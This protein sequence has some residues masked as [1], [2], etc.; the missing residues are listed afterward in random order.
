M[1]G[2]RLRGILKSVLAGFLG[3]YTSRYSEFEGYWLFGFLLDAPPQLKVDL[4]EDCSKPAGEPAMRVAVELA[5]TKFAEQLE[6][7]HVPRAQVRTALLSIERPDTAVV[8]QVGYE[9]SSAALVARIRRGYDLHL[10]VEVVTENGLLVVAEST[11]F[12]A[13][14]DPAHEFRSGRKREP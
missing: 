1:A 10:R 14:H 7:A 9:G 5:R 12:A 8:R 11:V 3:T 2:M 13:S 6:K 4:L